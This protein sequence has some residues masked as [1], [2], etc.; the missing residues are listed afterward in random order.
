MGRLNYFQFRVEL[1]SRE[2]GDVKLSKTNQEFQNLEQIVRSQAAKQSYFFNEDV[3]KFGSM[4]G[5]PLKEVEF[6]PVP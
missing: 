6:S 1:N 2:F 5:M 3:I 4:P